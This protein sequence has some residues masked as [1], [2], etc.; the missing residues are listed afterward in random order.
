[1]A[2]IGDCQMAAHMLTHMG[3]ATH[4]DPF[5]DD[6]AA[7]L[8]AAVLVHV[9]SGEERTLTRVWH[10]VQDIKADLLPAAS[11]P[12]AVRTFAGHATLEDRVRSSINETLLTRLAF[13]ADPVLQA[14]T[15]TCD[16]RAGDLQAAEQPVTVFLS[17]P[18]AH[19]RRLRPLT[20]LLLQSLLA[21]LTHDIHLTSDGRRKLRPVLAMLDEFPQL[22][23]MDVLEHGIAVCAGYGVRMAMVCQD[24]DQ[25]R[26]AYGS[27]QSITANCTTICSIPGFSAH[28][29][30]TVARW[31]GDH[32]VA[33]LAKQ[34]RQGWRGSSESESEARV[35][36]LNPR[37]MLQ[38]GR[39]EVLVFTLGCA[40][41]WLPKAAYY[42]LRAFRG[43]YDEHLPSPRMSTHDEQPEVRRQ[44]LDA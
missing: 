7:A 27:H 6:A 32:A 30:Q 29:L 42:R 14:A 10:T 20:R 11:D 18:A 38:R 8:L 9:C 36:V 40:P 21:P 35:P 5:W 1:M 19:G 25:I 26:S 15:S 4:H 3:E 34:R 43:L 2:L 23:R 13:L 16:F 41:V 22:G 37:D 44:W 24:E 39:E 17:I 33:H 28:S 12:F 31:G